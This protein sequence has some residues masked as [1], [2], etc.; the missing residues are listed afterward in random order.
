MPAAGLTLLS[1]QAIHGFH[2]SG[3]SVVQTY[4]S[5]FVAKHECMDMGCVYEENAGSKERGHPPNNDNKLKEL[6]CYCL[7]LMGALNFCNLKTAVEL[8]KL[9][10][11][12]FIRP[13]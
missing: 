2:S 8:V 6:F 10:S 7:Q 9:T 4:S 13:Y 5:S 11:R 1:I 3:D 12:I